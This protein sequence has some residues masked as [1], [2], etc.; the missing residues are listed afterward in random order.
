ME[1][2]APS[3]A[4][5]AASSSLSRRF[6][7][8]VSCCNSFSSCLMA[9]LSAFSAS[10]ASKRRF[11]KIDNLGQF[12]LSGH[13]LKGLY[14]SFQALL[15]FV[16][17]RALRVRV[18]QLHANWRPT[19]GEW[20]LCVVHTAACAAAFSCL[21]SRTLSVT[22]SAMWSFWLF[23]FSSSSAT[24]FL[25]AYKHTK[26]PHREI[27]L[28]CRLPSVGVTVAAHCSKAADCSL[29]N[30]RHPC[31]YTYGQSCRGGVTGHDNVQQQL[32]K[33]QAQIRQRCLR[34]SVY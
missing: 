25:Q 30:L 12:D 9:A 16:Y 33:I 32:P 5:L 11:I 24:L 15:H 21:S 29:I 34:C 27:V 13:L 28:D 2:R 7:C 26:E 1:S 18:F 23:L 19:G 17:V 31:R 4:F 20:G 22:S 3:A 14:S 10:C 8:S 6:R